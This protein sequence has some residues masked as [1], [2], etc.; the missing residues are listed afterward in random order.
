[1]TPLGNCIVLV[2][3]ADQ[4]SLY[5]VPPYIKIAQEETAIQRGQMEKTCVK[6]IGSRKSA[7]LDGRAARPKIVDSTSSVTFGA[8]SLVA[9]SQF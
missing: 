2:R 1:M 9:V 8:L 4:L 3:L 6:A 5:S 7:L